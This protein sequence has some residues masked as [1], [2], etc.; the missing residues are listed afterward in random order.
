MTPCS[1]SQAAVDLEGLI[2]NK[3]LKT[4]FSAESTLKKPYLFLRISKGPLEGILQ[5]VGDSVLKGSRVYDEW[6]PWVQGFG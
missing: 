1:T 4:M 5:G 6:Q 3:E 2:K